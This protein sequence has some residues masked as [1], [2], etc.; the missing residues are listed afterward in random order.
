MP[1]ESKTN[2]GAAVSDYESRTGLDPM[3][4][5]LNGYDYPK[6]RAGLEA[7]LV[8]DQVVIFEV[9]VDRV[10]YLNATAGLILEFCDGTRSVG[11]IVTLV[12]EAYSLSHSPI[13][14]VHAGL[15]SLLAEGLIHL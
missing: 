12:G 13:E 1:M 2:L 14:Q 7:H 10:H 6:R 8:D 3:A 9:G 4:P 5:G 11:E 15:Q